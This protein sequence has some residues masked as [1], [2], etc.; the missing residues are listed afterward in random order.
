MKQL[1][2]TGERTAGCNPSAMVA[3][4][5]LPLLDMLKTIKRMQ[6][7]PITTSLSKCILIPQRNPSLSRQVL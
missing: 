5:R 1:H 7:A 6:E 2:V 3:T 4:L